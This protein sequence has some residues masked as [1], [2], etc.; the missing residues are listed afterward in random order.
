ML[1][2]TIFIFL[3]PLVVL[4]FIS[5]HLNSAGSHFPWGVESK[6]IAQLEDLLVD[7]ANKNYQE[8]TNFFGPF[9]DV[10]DE[11][12]IYNF[13][14]EHNL[15]FYYES[16]KVPT[17]LGLSLTLNNGAVIHIPNGQK[18]AIA[19]SANPAE[20]SDLIQASSLHF[21]GLKENTP[22]ILKHDD[23]IRLS[24]ELDDKYKPHLYFALLIALVGLMVLLRT[25]LE[26]IRKPLKEYFL[27]LK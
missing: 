25:I 10:A 27:D 18:I 14:V 7:S 12:F 16:E 15:R 2:K 9:T 24:L 6:S 19:T 11:W 8:F 13:Y 23:P 26:F 20:I 5:N 21:V 3:V 4:I 17:P 1:A 22:F